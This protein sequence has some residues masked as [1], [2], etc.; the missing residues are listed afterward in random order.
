M[1]AGKGR[2]RRLIEQAQGRLRVEVYA[3]RRQQWIHSQIEKQHLLGRLLSQ[4]LGTAAHDIVLRIAYFLVPTKLLLFSG[5][6]HGHVHDRVE[7]LHQS[8]CDS[9]W[10]TVSPMNARIEAAS[11]D[12]G[13]GL[14][15]VCGGL[16][17]HPSRARCLDSAEVYC[18]VQ[19]RWYTLPALRARRHGCAGAVI[20]DHLYVAGGAGDDSKYQLSFE[21]L[22][23]TRVEA[24]L[25][26]NSAWR[27]IEP[28]T[29]AGAKAQCGARW[30]SMTKQQRQH[31][32]NGGHVEDFDVAASEEE[33]KWC[34]VP[35]QPQHTR[36]HPA[37]G[38]VEGLFVLAG[39]DLL[40]SVEGYN[41]AT[42][43][44]CLL[45]PTPFAVRA[46]GYCVW[47]GSLVIAGGE[48][49]EGRT[50]PWTI[51]NK[52]LRFDGTAWATMPE[53]KHDRLAPAL[54]VVT[55][56]LW[57]LGGVSSDDA[58]VAQLERF[59]SAAQEWVEAEPACNL[60]TPCHVCYAAAMPW[61]Q[62]AT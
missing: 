56:D 13:H 42:E 55:G 51:S 3:M 6:A 4:K 22:A 27:K 21:R 34:L 8:A 19:R 29:L 46:G 23:L 40:G 39:G 20:G 32:L 47:Q 1:N 41:P 48:T 17:D 44:W 33:E 36:L 61:F 52:V 43:R 7:A 12:L 14:F 54:A 24:V 35:A 10:E 60:R 45:P 2:D 11:F 26:S 59:D 57:V 50:A 18:S 37:A 49:A 5:F 9:R 53:M 62:C 31:V 30:S 28:T 25:L 38:E 16:D 15:A 58:F